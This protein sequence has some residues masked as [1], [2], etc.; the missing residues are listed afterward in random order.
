M[1]Y[2]GS[3]IWS[4]RFDRLVT[5]WFSIQDEITLAV[6]EKVYGQAIAGEDSR[7][8][9]TKNLQAF[10]YS[11]KGRYEQQAFTPEGK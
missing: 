7:R 5:D 2:R 8:V 1:P 11:I 3:Q 6:I 4:S 10:I 9:N